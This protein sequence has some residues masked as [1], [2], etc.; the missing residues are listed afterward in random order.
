MTGQSNGTNGGRGANGDL[1]ADVVIVGGGLGGVAAT[2]AAAR[3]GRRVVLVEEIDWIGGQLTAQ[4]VP[5]DEHPWIETVRRSTQ[6]R[7]APASDPRLLPPPLP[8]DRR[9]PGD[10]PST[11]AR[12][13]SARSATSRGSRCASSTK[14]SRRTRG[15]RLPC[16]VAARCRGPVRPATASQA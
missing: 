6:L 2:L 16:S 5:P 3:L 15:G 10:A 8:A 9:A 1:A 13:T 7:D 11:P 14:C 12:A 4:A